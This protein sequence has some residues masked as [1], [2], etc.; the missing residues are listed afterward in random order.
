MSTRGVELLIVGG[1]PAGLSA[2]IEARR[3]GTETLLVEERPSVGGQIYK[4]FPK[5]FA[6]LDAAALGADHIRAREL[7]ATA[8]SSGAEI[9]T[10]T[11]AWG[12]W[13]R[14]VSL[15]GNLGAQS[16]RADQII[17]A[18]GSFDRPVA[19]PGWTLPGVITAGGAQ[20]LTKIQR[21][22]PGRRVLVAGT[23]PVAL[24]FAAQLLA[25]G[26]RVV[27]VVEAAPF[28]GIVGATNLLRGA[29][30]NL[31]RLNQGI[32][33]LRYLRRRGVPFRYSQMIVG[34]E[35]TREVERAIVARVDRQWRP[36]SGTER[37][38]P[39]D[40]VCLGYGFS[41]STELGRLAGCR[42][43][44]SATDGGLVPV[45]EQL[46]RSSVSGISIAG[47]GAGI[48]GSE[49]ALVEGRLAGIAAA[50]ALDHIGA[51][52]AERRTRAAERRLRSLL[53]FH[54]SLTSLYPPGP[55]VY[56]LCRGDTIVCRCEEVTAEQILQTVD[57][58]GGDPNSVKALTRAGMGRCQGRNC[59]EQ[60]AAIVARATNR[61]VSEVPRLTIRP[62]VKP[63]PLM[64]ALV[65]GVPEQ[66]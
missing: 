4:Q 32:G 18:T 60:I 10:N 48:H 19:F 11:T 47:D 64:P 13:G 38:I 26:V 22:L 33:Y 59:G 50:R 29:V 62:P 65:E 57:R 61:P 3:H 23:G 52:E 25:A 45:R 43:A 15:S 2:A 42:H 55:G 56:E 16:I 41:P 1:G 54:R 37:A 9:M 21:V 27:E 20:S 24:A 31:P 17:L 12:I 46:V 7:I 28:P 39:V 40:T 66:A 30:G 36:I 53:R 8:L 51:A 6:V 5:E 14:E 44:Y 35:G 49:Q 63:V 34:V 58:S